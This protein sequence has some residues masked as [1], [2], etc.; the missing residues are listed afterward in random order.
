MRFSS[1]VLGKWGIVHKGVYFTTKHVKRVH[2]VVDAHFI[3]KIQIEENK[4]PGPKCLCSEKAKHDDNFD[5]KTVW[6]DRYFFLNDLILTCIYQ[7]KKILYIV[8][9]YA[10]YVY[11]M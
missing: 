2:I 8:R 4:Y 7:C 6:I 11:E 9:K 3:D 5:S 10:T 1:I